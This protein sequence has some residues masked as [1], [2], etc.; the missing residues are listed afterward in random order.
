MTQVAFWMWSVHLPGIP[1]LSSYRSILDGMWIPTLCISWICFFQ[2]RTTAKFQC[3]V[4]ILSM[5]AS[6][7]V[8]WIFVCHAVDDAL[9]VARSSWMQKPCDLIFWHQ[10]RLSVLQK[11]PAGVSSL[12]SVVR[13]SATY[14]FGPIKKML[15]NVHLCATSTWCRSA[16]WFSLIITSL[17]YARFVNA[18]ISTT[19]FFNTIYDRNCTQK[20]VVRCAF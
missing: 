9:S 4:C 3:V 19:K 20:A 18:V 8:L 14:G 10:S 16:L 6:Q 17:G 12:C 13:T 11:S 1:V 7:S 15:A 2:F 5:T